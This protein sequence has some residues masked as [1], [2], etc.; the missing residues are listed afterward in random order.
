V[1]AANLRTVELDGGIEHGE[2]RARGTR[3]STAIGAERIGG[4]IFEIAEGDRLF[5]FHYHHGVE[6]WLIV[7][8]GAPTLRTPEGEQVLRAGDC[9]CFPIGPEGAHALRGPG[10]VLMLS[11]AAT[12]SLSVPVYPD[13]DKL[14]VRAGA[15][16]S[17]DNLTFRRADAVDYWEGE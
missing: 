15:H 14:G 13:S 7:L 16:D 4:S 10:R 1:K 9:V 17:P 11:T 12:T 3:V 5:P 8:D 6:E 2:F